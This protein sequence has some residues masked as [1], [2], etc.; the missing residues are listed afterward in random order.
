MAEVEIRRLRSGEGEAFVRSVRIPFLDPY[1]GTAGPQMERHVAGL[2]AGRAW[3]GEAG[4]R[5]VANCMVRTMDVTL[6]APPAAACPVLPMGG[7]T[8]VGVHPTH[9]RRG[10]LGRMMA[11]MLEDCRSRGE[12][13][14]GLIASES[15]IYGR[16]GFG[17]VSDSASFEIDTRRSRFLQ[18][19]PEVA[20]ELLEKD[21][22]A[23]LLPPLF[24]RLRRRRAAEPGR[25]PAMWERYLADDPDRRHG[26]S[27]AL[28]AACEDGYVAYRAHEPHGDHGLARIEVEELRGADPAV[29]AALWRFVF[30]IDLSD[31]VT[32]RRRPVDEPLRWRLADHRQLRLT[33]LEDRLHVRILDVPAVLEARGYREAGRLVLD[34]EAPAVDGGPS[35]TAPG[36]WVLEA[37]PDGASCRP[38]RSGEEPDLRLDLTVL[39][40]LCMG[41]YP[42][43]LMLAAGRVQELAPGAAG[44]ADRLLG[45]WPAPLSGTGF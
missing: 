24:D 18:P 22:A 19:A 8:A 43:S 40:S 13:L 41:G 29:E 33:G 15:V 7:V 27:A 35:D 37:A 11:A 17:A 30:D 25:S 1:D 5:F 3:V 9:R 28:V 44:V 21:R 10:I 31:R 38:A 42:A 12:P 14:A 32:A 4:G 6:P 2:E 36:R 45:T 39:G 34:V 26:G 23:E 16:Y 20:L